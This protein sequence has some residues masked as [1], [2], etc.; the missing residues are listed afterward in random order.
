MHELAQF[1]GDPLIKAAA[2]EQVAP[3]LVELRLDL[4][5]RGLWGWRAAYVA[6]PRMAA[7]PPG[8]D[9]SHVAPQ[10]L[11]LSLRW[12]PQAMSLDGLTVVVDAGHGGPDT[13][14]VGVGGLAEKSA[15]LAVSNALRDGLQGRGA[16]VVMTRDEDRAV[17]ATEADELSRRV[18]I[19]RDSGGTVFISVHHNAR[20]IVE[21]ARMARGTYIYYYRQQSADLAKALVAPV[22]R[23]AGERH[24]AHIWRSFHVTRQPYMPSVLLEITFISN[25]EMEKAMGGDYAQRV[26]AGVIEGLEAFLAGRRD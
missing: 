11:R 20:P 4:H 2:L 8:H 12:P 13:G 1:A 9:F 23:A 3:G 10:T 15:N 17:A 5:G 24:A 18:A 14:A 7:D 21:D 6:S 16:R 25:P 22:A 26:A 19:G